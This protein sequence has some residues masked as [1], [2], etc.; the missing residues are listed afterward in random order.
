MNVDKGSCQNKYVTSGKGS[1]LRV[2]SRGLCT[3]VATAR[4]DCGK[5]C[6]SSGRS[7]GGVEDES[8]GG[9]YLVQ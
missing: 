5:N 1:A 2:G 9:I 6:G 7:F 3:N 8:F 4:A